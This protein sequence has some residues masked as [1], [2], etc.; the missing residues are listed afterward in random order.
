MAINDPPAATTRSKPMVDQKVINT[1]NNLLETTKDGEE[2]FRTCS[3]AVTNP[4]LKMVFESAAKKC[5]E[6][7][8]ELETK[9]R[10]L[11]GDPSQSGTVSG[12]LHRAWT[13]LKSSIAG[14]DEYA[15]LAECERGEDVA[16]HA[17]EEALQENL[18][19]DVA[20]IVRRQYQG[21]VNNHDQIRNLRDRAAQAR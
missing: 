13:N 8:A 21:V 18:P 19:E 10:S 17:Y 12:S 6:G 4:E 16:K 11:G 15:V 20:T 2:G 9:I 3:A 1:L 14:M 5:D 7:A